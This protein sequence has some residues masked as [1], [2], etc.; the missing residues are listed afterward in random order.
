MTLC[1]FLDP[2]LK[3]LAVSTSSFLG[4]SLLEPNWHV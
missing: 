1:Q 4:R 3:K 2:G